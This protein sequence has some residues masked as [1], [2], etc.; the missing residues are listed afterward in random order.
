MDDQN[1]ND[2]RKQRIENMEKLSEL[3]FL[4]YKES[5]KRSG[6]L[7]DLLNEFS[8]NKDVF[9]C[10][11]ILTIRKMGKMAFAHI[12]DGSAKFQIMVKKDQIGE[13]AFNAFKLLDIGDIIGVEG[14]YFLT[15][16]EEKTISIN[17]WTLLTK[18][19]LPFPEKFHG[20]SDKEIRYRQR[21][22][23]LITNSE[24]Q[25][26]FKNRSR[27]IKEI[28]YFLDN[29]GYM[30]VETPMLQ[31]I[32][33]GAAAKP[34][35]SHYNALSTD[36]YMRIAP[37]L[38]LK[39]LIV[40]GLDR[41]YEL[42]RNFRNEGI[43]RT[44]NPE[45]TCLE[46]YEAYGDMRSM[47]CLVKK[48]FHHIAEKVFQTKE[49]EWMGHKID[50][51]KEWEEITYENIIKKYLG[52][53]WFN[54]DLSFAINEAN[55]RDIKIDSKMSF[56]EITHEI[57]EKYIE[58]SIIQPTFVTRLPAYLVPLAKRCS[59]NNEFVDVFEL[60]I[61][62]KEIAPAYSELNDPIDQ[63][64]R[65]ENQLNE[66]AKCIDDDFIKALEYGM[67]PTGGMG[68]GIDR[69]VMFLTGSEGIRDV[70]L[71]PQLKSKAN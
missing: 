55:K 47:Q 20:L 23:D 24:T 12:N 51:D 58:P 54:E 22:L 4:S 66:D 53:N 10:G 56:Q 32:P 15:K 18:S 16:T 48:L 8:L 36:V 46:I 41:V 57:Y 61:G 28:R 33:G 30:E 40:G 19:L 34:F 25:K 42:N 52:N 1:N 13:N 37:E 21:S 71:F 35:K 38:Y 67:P 3:G 6:R 50:L 45:F 11:R 70:I 62:G 49:F 14:V 60:I 29:Y 7:Q 31:Q 43:D 2:Y 63:K 44:H 27:I 17:S 26:L 39:R 65:F 59:D 69:L 9:A 68:I 64:N 5:F